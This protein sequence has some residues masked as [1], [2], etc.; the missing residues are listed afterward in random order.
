M[1]DKREYET[2]ESPLGGANLQNQ[3]WGAT[4]RKATLS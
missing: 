4:C 1:S 2:L 3:L